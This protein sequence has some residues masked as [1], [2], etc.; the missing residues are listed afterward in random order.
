MT[1]INQLPDTPGVYTIF[2]D[3]DCLYAGMTVVAAK[4]EMQDDSN[5]WQLFKKLS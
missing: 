2:A 3:N 5:N 1:W 4:I